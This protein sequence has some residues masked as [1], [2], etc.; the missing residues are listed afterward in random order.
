MLLVV[1]LIPTKLSMVFI[2]F[3]C[4]YA[5]SYKGR[6]GEKETQKRDELIIVVSKIKS[7]FLEGKLITTNVG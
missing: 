5:S 6:D 3:A 1:G 2:K 7:T 4:F